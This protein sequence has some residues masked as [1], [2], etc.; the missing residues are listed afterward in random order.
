MAFRWCILVLMIIV[1]AACGT[2]EPP[3]PLPEE[4]VRETAAYLNQLSGFHFII[5]RTGAPAFL[6]PD[7]FISF[8]RAEGDYV[9]PDKAQAVVRV[10]IPGLVTEVNVISIGTV[11]WQTNVVTGVWEKLPPK[12]GFNPATLFDPDV[13][14][15]AILQNDLS[16]LQL[17]GREPLEGVTDEAV[18]RLTAVVA[19]EA[20]YQMSGTLIGPDPVT[21][22]FWIDPTTFAPLRILVTEPVPDSEDP[23]VWQIDFAQFGQVVTI[24]PPREK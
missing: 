23:S 9:A 13:G 2:A 19:G 8:R 6:D 16:D 3:A 20:I 18:Y 10:T 1:L 21:A 5:E 22:E 12:W 15:Q 24:E 17:A 4:I 11:Q 14:F 7:N